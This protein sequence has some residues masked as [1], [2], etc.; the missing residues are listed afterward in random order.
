VVIQEQQPMEKSLELMAQHFP[1]QS[2][3]PAWK[4]ISFLVLQLD[5]APPMEHGLEIC[6]TV[7]VSFFSIFKN[8]YLC[9]NIYEYINVCVITNKI[10]QG[11]ES[12]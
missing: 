10:I 7:Q 6:L 1:V 12:L 3:I 8:Y 11:F 5:S 2:F 9:E 4:D